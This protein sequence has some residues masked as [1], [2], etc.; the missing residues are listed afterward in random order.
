[1]GLFRRD[2]L[3]WYCYLCH[4]LAYLPCGGGGMMA[5]HLS[6]DKAPINFTD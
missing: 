3:L 4:A 2:L 6:L 5:D 1:M